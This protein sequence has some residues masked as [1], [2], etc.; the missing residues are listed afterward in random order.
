LA[1]VGW[2]KA[3][4][5]TGQCSNLRLASLFRSLLAREKHVQKRSNETIH[6]TENLQSEEQVFKLQVFSRT[7]IP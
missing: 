6:T 3:L 1:Y 2:Q 7:I 5:S 4:D